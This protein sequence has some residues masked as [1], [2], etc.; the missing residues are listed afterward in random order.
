MAWTRALAKGRARAPPPAHGARGGRLT[1]GART[2]RRRAREPP[3]ATDRLPIV[4]R[5]PP[6][7]RVLLEILPDLEAPGPR[8]R[9]PPASTPRRTSAAWSFRR[10][11][12]RARASPR[13]IARRR[14]ESCRSARLQDAAADLARTGTASQIGC[15]VGTAAPLVPAPPK[16]ACRAVALD[17]V[18]APSW[19]TSSS[20][21]RRTG[22]GGE[23]PHAEVADP[24]RLF[25]VSVSIL[26]ARL[27]P[28]SRWNITHRPGARRTPCLGPAP[29]PASLDAPRSSTRCPSLHRAGSRRA[30]AR[31][32]HR[33]Y[34]GRCRPF[35]SRHGSTLTRAGEGT[36]VP[37]RSRSS[38]RLDAPVTRSSA[39]SAC[40][41]QR[42]NGVAR[43]ATQ[44]PRVRRDPHRTEGRVAQLGA[45][46][47]ARASRN[48]LP[49]ARVLGRSHRRHRVRTCDAE[50]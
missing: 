48:A 36:R 33:L 27:A 45:M 24:R 37:A 1:A 25:F 39:S 8:R 21:A 47:R 49:A 5:G 34:D 46:G 4:S 17:E 50:A 13:R 28:R 3:R 40:R 41:A 20:Q 9:K 2:G 14:G 11:P 19:S 16:R 35:T 6:S 10:R 38:S 30:A 7:R 18:R 23:P 43:D 26:R 32:A 44:A 15:V 31:D 12:P 22:A 29:C 42:F